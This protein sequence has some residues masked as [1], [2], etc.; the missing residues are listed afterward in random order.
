MRDEQA[1]GYQAWFLGYRERGGATG[2]VAPAIGQ[3][4]SAD[5]AGTRWERAFAPIY[6]PQPHGWDGLFI[7]GPTVVRGPDKLWRL[8]YSGMGMVDGKG[9]GGI[10]LL[11][12]ADGVSWTA[13][14]DAPVMGVEPRHM[15]QPGPGADGDL[16]AGEGLAV[17]F[18]FG[19]SAV[20]ANHHRDWV[21]DF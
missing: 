10:G 16:R 5:K 17:V 12:S 8:Y 2:F 14:G 4:H 3:M 13:H 18:G 21:G 7:S 15:G 19:Q 20:A 9:T 11:T 1:D 6:R